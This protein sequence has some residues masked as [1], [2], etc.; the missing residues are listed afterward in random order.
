M[1]A[2]PECF[3][4]DVA[5]WFLEQ[6]INAAVITSAAG[7]FFARRQDACSCTCTSNGSEDV[8]AGRRLEQSSMHPLANPAPK[9]AGMHCV[10]E[11]AGNSRSCVC[12]QESISPRLLEASQSG[13]SDFATCY[14]L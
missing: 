8:N 1:Q 2:W 13:F 10:L 3:G 7:A 11:E 4:P 12:A 14:F 9:C 6:E 5:Y